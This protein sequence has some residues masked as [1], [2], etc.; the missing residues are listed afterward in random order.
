M[1]KIP[2]SEFPTLHIDSIHIFKNLLKILSKN[3]ETIK[4]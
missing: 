1:E 2:K 3:F 4:I